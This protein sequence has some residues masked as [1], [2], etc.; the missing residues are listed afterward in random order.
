MEVSLKF[1]TDNPDAWPGHYVLAI[2]YDGLGRGADAVPEYQKAVKLSHG[3]TDT[4]AGLL[5]RAF[6]W[7]LQIVSAD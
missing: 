6:P 5:R 3:D 4:V 1:I 7:V 2:D